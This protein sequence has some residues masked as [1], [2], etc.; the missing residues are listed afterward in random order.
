MCSSL[1]SRNCY[2]NPFVSVGSFVAFYS[3]LA[4][5]VICLLDRFVYLVVQHSSN[6]C[7]NQYTG[8]EIRWTFQSSDLIY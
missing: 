7:D 6:A 2:A 4:E 1:S 3:V 5:L 8:S